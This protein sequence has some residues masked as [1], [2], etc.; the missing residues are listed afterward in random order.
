MSTPLSRYRWFPLLG[1]IALTALA[2]QDDTESPVEPQFSRDGRGSGRSH[3]FRV[4][5]QNVYLG[6]DTG[7]IFTLDF[8]DIPAVLSAANQFWGEVQASNVPERMAEFVDEIDE[9]RPHVVALQEVLRFVLLDASFNPT[10]GVD[11][12]AAIEGEIAARGLPYETAV[13]QETTSSTLPLG[14]DPATG[15]ISQWLNF[16]DRVV[17][18]RRSDVAVTDL[19]KGLYAASLPLGPVELVR[20]WARLTVDHRGTPHHFVA[21]HLETQAARPLHDAQASELQNNVVAGLEGV[22]IIAG[23]LNSDAAANEGEPS[24]TA[25]Y[26]NLIA[27]GFTDVW[28]SSPRHR[29][30][31]GVTCCQSPNLRENS[32]LD[33]RIDFILVRSSE[34]R[35]SKLSRQRGL[36]RAEVVG[37]ERSD[38]T[39]SGLWP[40]DHAGIAATLRT[41]DGGR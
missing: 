41:L 22:T 33:E 30:V 11:L 37:D 34:E 19:A 12:L 7:P 26:G 28:E 20:G 15:G 32:E 14:F 39:P 9:R 4:Y 6:G 3:A 23:D 31:T 17:I 24:W 2:C 10:G 36:F 8:S 21:T 29:R 18:L 13:I 38:L 35:A 40:S 16:T 5:T 27:D 25:T 1:L